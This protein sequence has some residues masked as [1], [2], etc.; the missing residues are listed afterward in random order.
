MNDMPMGIKIFLNLQDFYS[1]S[2][3]FGTYA[4]NGSLNQYEKSKT[5]A[6]SLIAIIGFQINR[7]Q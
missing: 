4:L 7:T 3:H 6:K 5:S 2:D 1:V